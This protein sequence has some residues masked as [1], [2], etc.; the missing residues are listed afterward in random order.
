M[1]GKSKEALVRLDVPQSSVGAPLPSL[2]ADEQTL[3]VCYLLQTYEPDWDGSTIRV[4]EQDS[5]NE[6]LAVLKVPF[7]R[8]HLFG[9]P[10]DEAISGHRLAKLGLEP[11]SAFEVTNSAWI[12]DL[13]RANRVHPY[14]HASQYAALRHFIFTFHDSVLEFIAESFEVRQASSPLRDTLRR[15]VDEL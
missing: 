7:C 13:E 9:P 11:F 5:E 12:A 4:V 10:N 1:F 8:A 2:V 15:L 3:F 14:H 6:P